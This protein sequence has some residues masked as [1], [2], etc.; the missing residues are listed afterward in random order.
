MNKKINQVS[1]LDIA[2]EA[3]KKAL[4][5][6]KIIDKVRNK[7][8]CVIYYMLNCFAYFLLGVYFE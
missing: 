4:Y 3:I 7:N 2:K 8:F 5:Q 6:L 1:L